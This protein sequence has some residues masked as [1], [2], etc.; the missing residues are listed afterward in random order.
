LPLNG[1]EWSVMYEIKA[2]DPNEMLHE[3]TLSLQTEMHPVLSP[4][5]PH[6]NPN[7]DL[8]PNTAP[9]PE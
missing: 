8:D 3:L 2:S 4:P 1:L 9:H 5:H 7:S 6:P